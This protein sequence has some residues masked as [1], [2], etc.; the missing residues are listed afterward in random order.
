MIFQTASKNPRP[1]RL[2]ESTRKWAFESL[3]GIYGDN[4][5]ENQC[6]TL[7]HIENFESM[8]DIEKYDIAIRQI[9]EKAPLRLCPEERICG[10][11][12][13]GDAIYHNVPVR[14]KGE[15]LFRSVSHLT[16]RYDKVLKQ[17]LDV[18]ANDIAVRLEDKTLSSSQI[19]FL[20]SLENVIESI[21]IWHGRYLEATRTVRPDLHKL[22]LQVPFSPAR[23]FHE[24]LQSLWFI[25]SFVRL[26]G[27]WP[28]IGRIDWLLGDFLKKDLKDGLL[29]EDEARELL[30]SFF[31][32]GCEWIQSNPP[33][34]SGDSQHYQNIVL[35]GLDSNGNE[36]TNEVTYLVLDIVEELS[37]SDF[38]IT[39]RLN[40][41]S[42]HMLK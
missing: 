37:I 26:C 1:I 12:T 6:I 29:S 34:G 39:V 42:P 27:N 40:K 38:P 24:A 21:R 33:V 10:A 18:Y 7:D 30:A 41:N 20:H 25:F 15:N 22:L 11:A 28:G 5:M 23:N 32:K 19:N 3:H 4:A 2:K 17:G 31:I 36:I 13:L 9:A 16:I 14:Y 35:A 8:S